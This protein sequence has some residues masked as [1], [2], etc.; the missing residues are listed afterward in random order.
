MD[1]AQDGPRGEVPAWWRVL[2][3]TAF[4]RTTRAPFSARGSLVTYAVLRTGC[5]WMTSWQARQTVRVLHRICVI[6][7]CTGRK[8]CRCCW[9]GVSCRLL[10]LAGQPAGSGPELDPVSAGREG[11]HVRV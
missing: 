7:A 6:F 9:P 8:L 4:L 2:L 10:V 1:L 3:R 5:P 11:Q